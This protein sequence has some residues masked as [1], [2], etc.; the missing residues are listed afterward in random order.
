[1][2]DNLSFRYFFTLE[3]GVTPNMITINTNFNQGATVS[4]PSTL[5]RFDLLRAEFHRY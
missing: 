2:G 1:M 4:A 5:L 3:P